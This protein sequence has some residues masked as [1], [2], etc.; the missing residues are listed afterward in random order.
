MDIY[1]LFP[2]AGKSKERPLECAD[3]RLAGTHF[4]ELDMRQWLYNVGY[5][6]HRFDSVLPSGLKRN[7]PSEHLKVFA[8]QSSPAFLYYEMEPFNVVVSQAEMDGQYFR[9][10]F[11]LKK[12]AALSDLLDEPQRDTDRRR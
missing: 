6:R 8:R 9:T 4:L 1:G 7:K 11:C 10:L 2:N 12:K 3:R 5:L